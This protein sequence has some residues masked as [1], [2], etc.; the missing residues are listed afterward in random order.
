[1]AR[2]KIGNVR[3]PIDYLKQLF[4]P[5]GCGWGDGSPSTQFTASNVNKTA[6]FVSSG[7]DMP[8]S[9]SVW[10]CEFYATSYDGS[11]N[12]GHMVATCQGG[13]AK[14]CVCIRLKENGVYSEWEWVNPPMI[15]DVEYRT[16]ERYMGKPVYARLVDC[17]NCPG[18]GSKTIAH[19]VSGVVDRIVSAQ[20]QL[21]GYRV[22][23]SSVIGGDMKLDMETNPTEIILYSTADY[24]AGVPC[25]VLLKYTKN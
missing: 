22:F 5:A 4:A 24:L 6:V 16:N 11:G 21:Q 19:N 8:T 13:V 7:G 17:N 3:H 23:P 20:G 10:L 1:M 15:V 18:K 9:D 2:V 12:Y 25:H 14:G